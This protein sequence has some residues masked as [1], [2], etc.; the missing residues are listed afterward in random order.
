L[1]IAPVQA[2]TIAQY[3]FEGNFNDISGNGL[4]G[5]GVGSLSFINN[6]APFSTTGSSSL[7]AISDFDFV[8]VPDNSLFYPT[9]DFTV[10]AFVRP[11]NDIVNGG[12]NA[13]VIVAK[14]SFAG[15][16]TFGLDAYGINYNN[17]N[18]ISSMGGGVVGTFVVN[19]SFGFNSGIVI[20]S[21]SSFNDNNWHHV[22]MTYNLIGGGQAKLSLYVDSNLEAAQTFAAQPLFF[23]DGNN[24]L[25]I[26]A[27]NHATADGTGFYRR[28]FAG[29]IDE[30]RISDVA[31]SPNQ[32]LNGVPEPLNILGVGTAVGFGAFF[33]RELNKKKKKGQKDSEEA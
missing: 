26:G 21:A 32:F 15:G 30:V 11:F 14:Q 2:A 13:H 33:K 27:G 31:L 4:N 19:I 24:P 10:E 7:N 18:N 22:A 5:I 9:G 17:G 12:T 29:Y 28:N 6:V 23:G 8:K 25:Y 16:G 20:T 1:A 3:N